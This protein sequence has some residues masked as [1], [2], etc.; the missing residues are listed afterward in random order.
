MRGSEV[1]ILSAAPVF[2]AY[3]TIAEHFKDALAALLS[4]PLE[5]IAEMAIGHMARPFQVSGWRQVQCR[6][7][8]SVG[9][10]P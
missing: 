9:G 2:S 5:P 10:K 7:K 4:T 3:V 8:F 6:G 1:R